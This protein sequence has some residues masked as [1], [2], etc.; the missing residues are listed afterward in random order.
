MRGLQ[1]FQGETLCRISLE[2]L[3]PKRHP[4]RKLR[5]LVDALLATMSTDFDEVYS[6]VGCSSVPPERLFNKGLARAKT[7]LI[8]HTKLAGQVLLCFATYNLVR[9]GSIGGWWDAHHAW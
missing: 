9:M 5:A 6:K 1:N 4:L 2:E 7:K 3:V 8:G